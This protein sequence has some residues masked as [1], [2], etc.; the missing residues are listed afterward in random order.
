MDGILPDV[1]WRSFRLR[2]LFHG[3]MEN[4]L[5]AGFSASRP[6]PCIRFDIKTFRPPLQLSC[7][8]RA[9]KGGRANHE[10]R[11][12]PPGARGGRQDRRSRAL[13]G[14]EMRKARRLAIRRA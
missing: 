2:L 3:L 5:M 14:A 8:K 6:T 7:L 11:P 9:C 4:P 12:V 1:R 13:Q 10:R